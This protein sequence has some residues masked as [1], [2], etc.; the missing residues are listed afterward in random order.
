MNA[1]RLTGVLAVLVACALFAPIQTA[2]AQGSCDDIVVDEAGVFGAGIDQVAT[3]AQKLVNLGADVRV[4]S[5]KTFG[6]AGNLDNYV[7]QIQKECN[8]WQATDGGYKNNLVVLIVAVD[9]RKTGLYYGSQWKRTLEPNWIRIQADKMNPRFR[10]G[11]FAG[12]FA[13]GLQE[14]QRLID[15]EIHPPSPVPQ[16]QQPQVVVVVPTTQP[17]E[18]SPPLDLSGLWRVLGWVVAIIVL[19]VVGYF[20]YQFTTA[21]LTR[22]AK[23]RAAQQKARLAKQ[24]TASRIAEWSEKFKG[25]ELQISVTAVQVAE[26]EIKPLRN[27]LVKAQRLYDKATMR[28][29]D[30]ESSAGDPNRPGLTEDEYHNIEGAYNK[31]LVELQEAEGL[32]NDVDRQAETLGKLVTDAPKAVAVARTAIGQGKSRVAAVSQRGFKTQDEVTLTRAKTVLNKAESSLKEKRFQAAQK[33]AEEAQKLANDAVTS[34]EDLPKQKTAAE[35]GIAALA[36]RIEAVKAKIIAGRETFEEFAAAYAQSCWLPIRGNGTEAENRINW[37]LRVLETARELASME[38]QEWQKA[39]DQMAEANKW[40]DEAESFMRSVAALK[41]NLEAAKRGAPD[42]IQ[43]AQAD[44]EKA[45]TYIKKYD[46]D[47]RESLETD[48]A[49]VQ[50]GLDDAK[51]EL[52]KS[53]PDYLKVVKLA[54]QANASA[55]QILAEA[56]SEHEA[57]ERLRQRA[58]SALRDAKAAVSR[59]KEYIEDHPSDV[60]RTAKNYLGEAQET[61]RSAERTASLENRIQYAEKAEAAADKAYSRAESDVEEAEEERRPSYTY[62]GYSG[63]GSSSSQP[64]GG[65]GSVGFGSSSGGGGST[66]WGGS[67]GG[68]G[69]STGW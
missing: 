27:A 12:G 19:A 34:A 50:K 62:V 36:Q 10:D 43:A 67:G 31:A 3:E 38:K 39:Q 59:A 7:D 61:L 17:R 26:E 66:G 23:R 1:K 5:V 65:G 45:T 60:K 47:I 15:L 40:L 2:S 16:Q 48:L 35:Q 58:A 28:H 9:D 52:A 25:V 55:D 32:L 51:A 57:A 53:K 42:E 68:G 13:A 63:W 44:I 24:A 18:V 4:R 29:A 54:K 46:P 69:G 20:G 41:N 64:A 6:S 33:A 14:I 11:D 22:Q 30:L 21:Y 56:R 37:S 49:N 8:S